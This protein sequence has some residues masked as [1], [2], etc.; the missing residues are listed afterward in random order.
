MQSVDE[1]TSELRHQPIEFAPF[2]DDF[3]PEAGALLAARHR[4]DRAALPELPDRFEDPGVARRAVEAAWRR[5]NASGVAALEGGGMAGYLIADVGIDAFRGRSVWVRLAGHA[6]DEAVD[7]ELYRDLYAA[8]GPPWLAQGCFIHYAMVPTADEA[9]LAAWGD[10]GF[11]RDQVYALRALTDADAD[12]GRT[13]EGITIRRA[14]PDDRAALADM[15]SLIARSHAGPP[16]W[17]PVAPEVLAELREGYADLVDDPSWTV[18]L[19]LREGQVVGFQ[20]YFPLVAEDD[21]LLAAEG[22]IELKVAGTR[23]EARGWGIGLA[24]TRRG[25]AEARANDY[26]YCASDWHTPNLLSSRFWPRRGFRPMA[27]RLV[28]HIDP[29]IAWADGR[30]G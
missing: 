11:A 27:Y 10:L 21:N 19:A 22:C 14:T 12:P 26:T 24:L 8:A 25:L 6:L 16:A 13:P 17:V 15:S 29:R 2:R 23:E 7:A 5:P 1:I 20:A 4:R 18:W 28:R 9:V 3:L 30:S